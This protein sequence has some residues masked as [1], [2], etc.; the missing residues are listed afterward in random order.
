VALFNNGGSKSANS[1]ASPEAKKFHASYGQLLVDGELIETGF[2]VFRDTFIFTNKRLII[3]DV[4]GVSARQID[5][6]SV[7]YN[8]VMKFSVLAMGNFE[9]DAELKIWVG[10]DSLPIE[11]KF[12]A[13]VNVYEVQKLLARYVL[14]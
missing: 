11:K 2:T 8:R 9:L 7:P 4:K 13:S 14:K 10:N 12:D 3:V 5:Y 6:V 1:A